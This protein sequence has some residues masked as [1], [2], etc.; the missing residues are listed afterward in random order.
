MPK[1]IDHIMKFLPNA[2]SI[3]PVRRDAGAKDGDVAPARGLEPHEL[4]SR[5][6]ASLRGA[7]MPPDLLSLFNRMYEE[8]QGASA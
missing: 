1:L 2:I 8:A 4:V 7:E 3:E 6:Y 5:Y